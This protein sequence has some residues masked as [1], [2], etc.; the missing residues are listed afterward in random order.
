MEVPFASLIFVKPE[1]KNRHEGGWKENG[2]AEEI[3][4]ENFKKLNI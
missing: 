4:Y 3:E 2:A 1:I